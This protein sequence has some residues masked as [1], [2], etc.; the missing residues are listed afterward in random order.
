ML[1]LEI[2]P[3]LGNGEPTSNQSS[4]ITLPPPPHT[5]KPLLLHHHRRHNPSL[6]LNRIFLP[7]NHPTTPPP[8]RP[9]KIRTRRQQRL[10]FQQPSSTPPMPHSTS[11]GHHQRP[12]PQILLLRLQKAITNLQIIHQTSHPPPHRLLDLRRLNL[13]L[14]QR[15]LLGNRNPP[16]RRRALLLHRHYVHDRLR[17]HRSVDSLDQA[18]RCRLRLVRLRLPRYLA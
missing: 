9:R 8:A 17:R 2:P 13:L 7:R 6:N 11:H 3:F 15:P 16:R 4:S 10:L 12:H 18:L 5:G 14:Q 1:V